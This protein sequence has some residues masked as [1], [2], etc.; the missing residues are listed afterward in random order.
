MTCDNQPYD[1][2]IIGYGMATHRLLQAL[3]RQTKGPARILVLGEETRH[4]YNRVLLPLWVEDPTVDLALPDLPSIDG[5]IRIVTG[6]TVVNIDRP[7]QSIATASGRRFFYHKLVLATGSAPVL[8]SFCAGVPALASRVLTLR[9]QTDA[10]R[11]QAFSHGSNVV[12]QG[13]GFIALE[14]AAALSAHYQV[15]VCHRGSYLMNRQLD[16]TA[17]LLLQAALEARGIRVLLRTEIDGA[18]A[19]ADQLQLAIAGPDGARTMSTDLLVA[20]LGIKPRSDLAKLAGIAVNR[21]IVVN[22]QLQSSD[23]AIFAIGECAECDGET[24]GLVAPVYQQAD[25]LAKLLCG[26]TDVRYQAAKVATNLKIS[27]FTL[28]AVGDVAQLQHST[29]PRLKSLVYQDNTQGEYRRIWLLDG[30]LQGAVLCGDTSLV[31]HYQQWLQSPKTS[32]QATAADWLND[33]LFY[34]A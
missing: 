26:Q 6:E 7:H 5:R 22:P 23:P 11:I 8:P 20:A 25:T 9:N 27:G 21:G 1:L 24:V 12:I 32:D 17:A 16:E 3:L 28:S 13:G 29:D 18:V 15:T 14:T 31:S 30:Q 4:A 34:A 10:Q 2:I 19:T 33:W